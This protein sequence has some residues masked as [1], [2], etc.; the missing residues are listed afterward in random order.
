MLN[1]RQMAERDFQHAKPTAKRTPS[2]R[3]ASFRDPESQSAFYAAPAPHETLGGMSRP[4]DII[5]DRY[6]PD[7]SPEAREEARENLYALAA[8]VVRICERIAR[9]RQGEIRV[10]RQA[11]VDSGNIHNTSV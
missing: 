6:M 11:E 10:N 1:A 4:G 7:A 5:L 9:E 8:A 3:K 2:P